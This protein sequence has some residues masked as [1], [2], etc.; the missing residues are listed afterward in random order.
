VSQPCLVTQWVDREL[1][2]R[3]SQEDVFILRSFCMNTYLTM[4]LEM[5]LLHSDPYP[6]YLFRTPDGR[7]LILDWR[8]VTSLPP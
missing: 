3:S 4:L 7:L 2:H 8:M 5:G 1:L 6:G